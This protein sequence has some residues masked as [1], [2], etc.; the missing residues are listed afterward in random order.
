MDISQ[1]NDIRYVVNTIEKQH[2]GIDV[3]INNAGFG[4]YGS[5]EETTLDEARYQFEVNLFGLA[6]LTQ[7]LLPAMRVK[8]AGTIINISSM[9]GRVYSPLGAWYTASK[10]AVEGWSDSLRL[11]LRQ[12]GINVVVI[13]PGAIQTEFTDVMTEPMLQRSG[14]GPYAKLTNKVATLVDREAKAGGG[15]S[16]QVIT[17]VVVKALRAKRPKTR[18]IAGK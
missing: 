1:D 16:P 9:L 11:E 4:L 6:R 5:V 13:E 15:D 14:S 17:K 7:L 2:G 12:F 10:H 8:K 18:Y 3:L